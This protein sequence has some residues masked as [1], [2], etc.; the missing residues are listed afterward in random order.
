MIRFNRLCPL[1]ATAS[2]LTAIRI[3][4]HVDREFDRSV[5]R[6]KASQS[7][8][9]TSEQ[10]IKNYFELAKELT[11]KAGE[12]FKCG[13][14]GEKI[15]E[16][17]GEEWDLVTNYDRKIEEMLT[18]RLREE[19]PDHEFMGEEST[20]A[21]KEKPVLTDK[22]TW[23]ID[24]ID[25]TINYVNSFPYTCISVGLSIC[26]QLT[27]GIIYNPLAGELYTAIKGQGAFLNGKPIKTSNVTDLKTSLAEVELY[28]LRYNAHSRDI[29]LGRFGA[30]LSNSRGVRYMGSATLSLA[31]I[32]KGALDCL[33][34]DGLHPWDVAA[35]VLIIREAGGTVIDTKGDEYDFMKGNTIAAANEKLALE[36]KQLIIDTDLKTLRKRLA[37][38]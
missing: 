8:T 7:V 30:I 36:I 34:M 25:G 29:S 4:R 3:S 26:K 13:F 18:K 28:S 10:D 21:T 22:P 12:V 1:G 37:R 35:G 31:Y 15:V 6:L 5:V 24:P 2:S 20:D 11:L 14:E 17:K 38:T 23:I 32:A 33:Q 16:S 27:I 19:Y 9:M